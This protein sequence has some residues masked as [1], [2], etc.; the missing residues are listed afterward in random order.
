MRRSG[1]EC[2]PGVLVGWHRRGFSH[3]ARSLA[4]T[5]LIKRF[6]AGEPPLAKI[7]LRIQTSNVL[8]T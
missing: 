2:K 1:E 5:E 4:K 6:V 7:R 3:L 8:L